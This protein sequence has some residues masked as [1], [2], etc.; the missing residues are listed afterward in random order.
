MNS[1][2]TQFKFSPVPL[3]PLRVDRAPLLRQPGVPVNGEHLGREDDAEDDRGRQ[4]D[5]RGHCR[6]P[7]GLPGKVLHDQPHGGDGDDDD[8]GE[9]DEAALVEVGPEV[10]DGDTVE[11]GEEHED[12]RV[13]VE[14]E[15]A[16]AGDEADRIPVS[17]A[18]GDGGDGEV[19]LHHDHQLDH[20]HEEERE[21]LVHKG[22][23]ASKADGQKRPSKQHG[24]FFGQFIIMKL[25]ERI[26][27]R[28]FTSGALP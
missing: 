2:L 3:R 7:Q 8:Q 22:D 28:R 27:F 24:F 9:G 16:R 19:P 6:L 20:H 25:A 4:R 26:S 14:E 12:A 15:E 21:E 17:G 13:G 23:A 5:A 10:D 18:G 11:E 1:E